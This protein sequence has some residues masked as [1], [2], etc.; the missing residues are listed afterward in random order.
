MSHVLLEE[1][2]QTQYVHKMI[3][4]ELN[5]YSTRLEIKIKIRRNRY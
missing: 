5:L 1:H 3:K 2:F 4:L